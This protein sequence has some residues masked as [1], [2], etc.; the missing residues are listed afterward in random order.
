VIFSE[1]S[2]QYGIPY[3]CLDV[4]VLILNENTLLGYDATLI[5]NLLPAFWRSLPLYLLGRGN[6]MCCLGETV[7]LYREKAVSMIFVANQ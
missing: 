7:T 3:L 6:R 4:F 5:G 2:Y 1:K